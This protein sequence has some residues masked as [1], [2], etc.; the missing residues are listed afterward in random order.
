[1]CG[2]EKT[3]NIGGFNSNMPYS[4]ILK[5]KYPNHGRRKENTHTYNDTRWGMKEEENKLVINKKRVKVWN[6]LL[7]TERREAGKI[8]GEAE[9]HVNMV[10][11][12]I[13]SSR[14]ETHLTWPWRRILCFFQ[15]TT[16]TCIFF[17][18]SKRLTSRTCTGLRLQLL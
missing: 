6:N 18:F 12:W 17:C 13:G 2:T 1:M 16:F 9:E 11:E 10:S 3:V 8:L 4:R 15:R 7:D 5:L 14:T